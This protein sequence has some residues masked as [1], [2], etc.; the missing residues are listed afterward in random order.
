V[1]G[2][3]EVDASEAG[4]DQGQG[5]RDLLVVGRRP[6]LAPLG[7]AGA[8]H[9]V[10]QSEAFRRALEKAERSELNG[11]DRSRQTS[12]WVMPRYPTFHVSESGRTETPGERRSRDDN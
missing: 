4:K 8:R 11:F 3:V 7:A 2:R 12:D 1:K 5:L 6:T 9:R 10:A